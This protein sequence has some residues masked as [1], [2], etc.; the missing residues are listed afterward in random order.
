MQFKSLPE[1]P[2]IPEG[3]SRKPGAPSCCD[4][5][6][7]S[8]AR[9]RG[10]VRPHAGLLGRSVQV[11]PLLVM[12]MNSWGPLDPGLQSLGLWAPFHSR[13]WLP[14]ALNTLAHSSGGRC[15]SSHLQTSERAASA[16]GS[17]LS[18]TSWGLRGASVT[19][20]RSDHLQDSGLI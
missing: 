6:L 11:M 19:A 1:S 2:L 18:D 10:D 7:P 17:L 9:Q 13:T 15:T 4:S 16:R 20:L 14:H 12:S 5:E 3:Q 8:A